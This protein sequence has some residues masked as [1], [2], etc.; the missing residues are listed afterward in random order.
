MGREVILT[1]PLARRNILEL[2]GG[3]CALLLPG[4]DGALAHGEP[5]GRAGTRRARP[6]AAPRASTAP[7]VKALGAPQRSQRAPNSSEAG[8]APSPRVRLYQ[9][10]AAPRRS[11]G[12]RSATSAF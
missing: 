11:A 10:K 6:S 12:T 4:Y 5:A 2:T 1:R 7:K 3:T 9:P 8:S